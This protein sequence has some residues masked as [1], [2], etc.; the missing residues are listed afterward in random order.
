M[1]RKLP[2]LK[3]IAAFESVARLGSVTKAANELFVT[4][5]AISKQIAALEDWLGRPLFEANR[6]QMRPLPEAVTWARTLG[7][8]LDTLN[9][10]AAQMRDDRQARVLRIIAPSTM[11]TRWLI[12]R[13]WHF[14]EQ[15]G[16]IALQVR[17]TDSGE[18]WRDMPF[19]VAIRT[20]QDL[21]VP[22]QS[23][24][25]FSEQLTLAV[26]PRLAAKANLWRPADILRQRLFASQT[27]HGELEQWLAAAGL[28]GQAGAIT[29]FPHFYLAL[30]ATLAG[31]G[32]LICPRRTL[33]DQFRRGDL[34]EP[35]PQIRVAGPTFFVIWR[36]NTSLQ[37]DVEIFVQW[38]T[39]MA[40]NEAQRAAAASEQLH[41]VL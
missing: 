22:M 1:N 38:L 26:S 21:P 11:A 31:G 34:V 9:I 40:E 29:S 6:K 41:A 14:S 7:E 15:H 30:E 36:K 32:A 27:R 2:P 16:D 35:W 20:D 13:S 5:G 25:I 33:T 12:P 17:H 28:A 23:Q 37:K 39:R 10:S 3:S 4:H 18:D 19:D 8:V 24:K